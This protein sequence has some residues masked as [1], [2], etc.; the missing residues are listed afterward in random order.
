MADQ[1]ID[2][3]RPLGMDDHQRGD[4]VAVGRAGTQLAQAFFQHILIGQVGRRVMQCL[5]LHAV[6][7][8]AVDL[9]F[10]QQ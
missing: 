9:F 2:A 7:Q 1:I 4:C 5:V 8:R 6:G 10:G 3:A